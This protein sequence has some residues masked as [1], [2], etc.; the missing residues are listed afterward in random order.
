M[1][2]FVCVCLHNV[3]VCVCVCVCVYVCVCVRMG[4]TNKDV[5]Y[6]YIRV[7]PVMPFSRCKNKLGTFPT[8]SNIYTYLHILAPSSRW[9]ECMCVCE[10]GATVRAA[11]SSTAT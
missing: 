9:D 1:C 7:P 10:C 8:T 3:S 2:V 6:M 5:I 4:F 11:S